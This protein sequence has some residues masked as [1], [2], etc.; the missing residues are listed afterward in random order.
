[1][2]MESFDISP[3]AAGLIARQAESIKRLETSVSEIKSK[4]SNEGPV[5]N[6]FTDR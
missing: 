1:M 6:P 2:F 4:I 5:Y 3:R